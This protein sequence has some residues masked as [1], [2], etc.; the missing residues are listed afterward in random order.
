MDHAAGNVDPIKGENVVRIDLQ[1]IY[2]ANP[3]AFIAAS[4]VI[5]AAFAF[6]VIKG[7]SSS[8]SSSP[9]VKPPAA[10]GTTTSPRA[11]TT[12][13]AAGVTTPDP[14]YRPVYQTVPQTPALQAIETQLGGLPPAA[15]AAGEALTTPAPA[16][17]RSYPAVSGNVLSDP[18]GYAV[19]FA[20]ELLD[21]DYARVRRGQLLAWS[22]AEAAAELLPG[23]PD[24]VAQKT[25]YIGLTDP[26]LAGLTGSP[27]PS[28][29][30]WRADA[31]A[32]VTQTVYSVL[33]QPNATWSQIESEGFQ[34]RDPLMTMYDVTGV[35]STT[36]GTRT[37]KRHFTLVLGLG[38][39]LHH[40][41]FGAFAIA[42]WD[43]S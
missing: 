6:L 42:Q 40:R 14:N 27:V 19:A 41:G 11:A 39:A 4:A 43:V 22:Q 5:A 25:L 10:H 13:A 1:D 2:R 18:T 34:S 26:S 7:V 8:G 28:A 36:T 17:S 3:K 24:S 15:A 30:T 12:T 38:S 32:G 16:W 21:R 37:T 31:K 29:I 33:A 23:I 20:Q 9:S 35:L